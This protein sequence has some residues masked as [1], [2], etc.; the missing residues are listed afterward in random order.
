MPALLIEGYVPEELLALS[1][2][3]FR[4]LVLRA[5]PMVFE[6]GSASLLGKFASA[7]DTLIV[8]LAHIDGGGEG[9]LPTIA[10]I[11]RRVA[12]REGLSAIEWRVHAVHC[13]QPNLQLRRFLER[14]GF[15]IRT[16]EGVGECYWRLETR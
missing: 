1:P 9:V 6:A 5:E 2:D 13:A 8:E 15:V 14:R 4:A 16:I 10:G 7:G 12:E 11:A 3:E